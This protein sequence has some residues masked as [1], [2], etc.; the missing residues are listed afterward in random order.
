VIKPTPFQQATIDAAVRCLARPN[1]GRRFLVADEVGLGKTVVASG[2]IERLTAGQQPLKVVYV[3]SN[4][5]I[6]RQNA[7]RLLSFLP[8]A[9]RGN[10]IAQADRPS[11]LPT[12]APPTNDRVHV[13]ML[14]PDTA[15]P[16]RKGQRRDG[17]KEERALGVLMLRT[18]VPQLPPSV[19][20][21]FRRQA[22]KDSFSSCMKGFRD[23]L[24][25]GRIPTAFGNRFRQALREL[26]ALEPGQQLPVRLLELVRQR[27]F[28]ELVVLARAALTIAG[29]MSIDADL[30]VLDEFQRFRDLLQEPEPAANDNE[31]PAKVAQVVL[32]TIRGHASGGGP[33][34]LL[35]SA[36]PYSTRGH[37]AGAQGSTGHAADFF[38]LVAF[39]AGSQ[40]AARRAETLFEDLSIELRK[41]TIHSARAAGLRSDLVNLLAPLMSRVERGRLAR[42]ESTR[43]T[44]ITADLDPCD[45]LPLRELKECFQADHADWIVPLWQSVPLPMQSLGS[46]YLAWRERTQMP[47][48]SP[49]D[50]SARDRYQVPKPW[51]HP[52]LRALEARLRPEMQMPWCAPSLPW[53]KLGTKWRSSQV[54]G[55]GKLLVFS[56]FKAVPTSVAGLLS[57][58]AE[59]RLL[60]GSDLEYQDASVR[61]WLEPAAE[62]LELFHPSPLLASCDPLAD[63]ATTLVTARR[64][65]EKQLRRKLTAVG[66]RVVPGRKRATGRLWQLVVWIEVHAGAWSESQC[67]WGQ[68]LSSAEEQ[69]MLQQWKSAAQACPALLEIS[70]EGDLPALA[71]LA[72]SS[73]AVTALR[74]LA[75]HWPAATSA[76]EVGHVVRLSWNGLRRYLDKPWFSAALG[77]RKAR[78]FPRAIRE[79]VLD[80]NLESVLDEHFWYLSTDGV[81]DWRRRLEEL[82]EGLRLRDASVQFYQ[83]DPAAH[84]D[85]CTSKFGLRCHFAVPMTEAKAPGGTDLTAGEGQEEDQQSFRPD[86]VRKG[87]N[88]PF[89]PHVLVTTSIGQ[90]GLDLHPWSASLLHWDL[91]SSA[92]PLEQ[93]EGRITRFAGLAVR[94]AIAAKLKGEMRFDGLSSPWASLA[95]LAEARLRDDSGIAPWWAVE[96]SSVKNFVL[97]FPGSEVHEKYEQLARDRALYRLVLGMPDQDEL[98]RILDAQDQSAVELQAACIDL[99]AYARRLRAKRTVQGRTSGGT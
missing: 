90:E 71:A 12:R 60:G 83:Y 88:T 99:S 54:E 10:A 67:A 16:V 45:I 47:T 29:L 96:G 91:A 81:G 22:G 94:R 82:E 48:T 57:Y 51:P 85:R 56:R 46:R 66:I 37:S 38:E 41:G 69:E 58:A 87:F 40:K 33:R 32:Q 70:A 86:L 11:L 5:A 75:R 59:S 7:A 8:P 27:R 95:R 15:V 17:R 80:G 25:D 92:V 9:E 28:Q 30:V 77:A 24:R 61:R 26:M 55:A 68:L 73:P 93:R 1:G 42:F 52:R 6:A 74:A 84:V 35:L 63:G 44:S 31:L 13:Y 72:L 98:R 49:L 79:A 76:L 23:M 39:L 64:G 36:T 97:A 2:V 4:Q 21:H 89:W 53:W 62:R 34:L 78:D 50:A 43:A 18:A 3:C 19:Y 65:I 20:R 14:T